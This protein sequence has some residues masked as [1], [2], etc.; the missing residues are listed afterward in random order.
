[1]CTSILAH[2]LLGKGS[3]EQPSI[4]LLFQECDLLVDNHGR[5]F[6]YLRLSVT[7]ACNFRCSYCLP[8]GYR[9]C[10]DQPFLSTD[11]VRRLCQAFAELGFSKVRL[12]GGEPTLRP[13]ISH[14]IHSI[15]S[16]EGIRKVVLS[17]N[18]FR[19]S[20]RIDTFVTAG[21][22]GINVSVDSLDAAT[23]QHITGRSSLNEVLAGI[24]RALE[25]GLHAVKIN[26]VALRDINDHQWPL[27]LDYIRHRPVSVRFIE[28]MPGEDH[29]YYRKHHIPLRTFREELMRAG[30]CRDGGFAMDAGPAQVMRHSDYAGT[31]GFILPYDKNFCAQCNRLRVNAYGAL[32][33]CLFGKNQ[34]SLRPFLQSDDDCETLQNEI[35]QL[36]QLKPKSHR[37]EWMDTGVNGSF[38]RIGG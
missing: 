25:L 21:L 28:L 24:D 34:I 30:W 31:L 1:M 23:F 19:L 14:L 26:T 5:H 15:A 11:E 8:Q 36:L 35:I 9:P 3:W 32:R 7:E 33:L 17:T 18:G 20:K 4:S 16:M 22:S 2:E 13:D 37:L 6:S 38:S 12:T 10:S 29:N 27:F